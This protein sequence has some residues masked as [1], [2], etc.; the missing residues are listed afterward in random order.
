MKKISLAFLLFIGFVFG[1]H[2]QTG[3]IARNGMVSSAHPLA[4]QIGVDIMKKGG[5]AYDAAVAVQFALAVAYPRA[6]NISGGGFMVYRD[7][8]GKKGSLDFREKA[9]VRAHR[10]MYL[11]A[12]GNVIRDLSLKGALAV[13][14]PGS[15]DGMFTLWQAKGKLDWKTL[16]QPAID[17]AQNGVVLT[18]AE[19][20]KLNGYQDVLEEVNGKSTPYVHADKN[21]RSGERIFYPELA[22]TLRRIQ[23]S[24]RDGFYKGKTARLLLK[25]IQKNKGIITQE[26]LD[27]YRSVWR[28]TIAA[29]YRGYQ[30][31]SM[32]PPSSGGI[33]LAQLFMGSEEKQLYRYPHN[34]AEAIHLMTELE[35]RVYADR[36]VH[37][38]DPDFFDV[39]AEMLLNPDY[40][41][42]RN[43]GI[44]MRRKTDS[45]E[46]R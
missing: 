7:A 22:K 26:D 4:S 25:T 13:G 40:N 6:G 32:P 18:Q 9:P 14:V 44:S 46:I 24:G 37:L 33:A 45:Q 29:D 20:E 2:A 3:T 19:A 12:E 42:K 30:I 31:S 35:R 11:D 39:P 17:L 5:N 43:A 34:S 21:W 10:D 23:K 16:V 38:G 1:L 15:V 36:S 28:G 8:D 41:R 27:K